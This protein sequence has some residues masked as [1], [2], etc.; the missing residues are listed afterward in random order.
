[1]TLNWKYSR[2]RTVLIHSNRHESMNNMNDGA[3]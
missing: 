1:M 3:A 2:Q